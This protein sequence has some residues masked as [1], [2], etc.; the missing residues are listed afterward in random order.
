MSTHI[1][2]ASR[3]KRFPFFSVAFLLLIKYPDKE[4]L[5]GEGV[6]FLARGLDRVHHGEE[7]GHIT[8]HHSKETENNARVIFIQPGTLSTKWCDLHSGWI[9]PIQLT[10][11]RKPLKKGLGLT[12][13][14][15]Q[16]PSPGD[17]RSFQV[18]NGKQPSL[19]SCPY[20]VTHHRILGAHPKT[21]EVGC[22]LV[23]GVQ[24]PVDFSESPALYP[25]DST[26][27]LPK[28]GQPTNFL[29]IDKYSL[30][31][32]SNPWYRTTTAF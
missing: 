32:Q 7:A 27:F 5:K 21:L 18:D 28:W 9:F 6:F 13:S 22:S 12:Y 29:D 26:D 31:G 17:F 14:L 11:F 25:L 1:A 8:P 10:Y 20:N 16:N 2:S 23:Q 15:T 4:Q 24:C 30:G 3:F 19:S